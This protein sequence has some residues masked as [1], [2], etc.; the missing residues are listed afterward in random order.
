MSVLLF[1][2]WGDC[3]TGLVRFK[4]YGKPVKG[5][6]GSVAMLA[7][8]LAISRAFVAPFWIG[9]VASAIAV[10]TEWAFG[11]AGIIRWADDN[12]AIP[13]TSL[14]GILGLLALT[15]SL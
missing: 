14:A 13:V 1:M 8:C 11:D 12:W 4:V 10:A 9:A 3:V 6:W 5:L 15:H 2:A 7:V